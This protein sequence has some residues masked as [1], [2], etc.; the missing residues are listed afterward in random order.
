MVANRFRRWSACF[1]C[2]C[3]FLAQF[4]KGTNALHWIVVAFESSNYIRVW[5][6]TWFVPLPFCD[7]LWALL[8]WLELGA[9]VVSLTLSHTLFLLFPPFARCFVLMKFARV[10]SV[11]LAI[12][13]LHLGMV[14]KLS[15]NG[16]KITSHGWMMGRI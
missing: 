15:N 12:Y 3:S 16:P 14:M 4:D 6:L 11:K 9:W 13:N 7:S 2:L 1:P 8:F 5:F 10:S